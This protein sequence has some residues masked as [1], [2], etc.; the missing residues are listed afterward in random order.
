MPDICNKNTGVL[1][2][3]L[4]PK[5]Y[6][7]GIESGIKYEVRLPKAD[8]F[9]YTPTGERQSTYD[10]DTMSCATFSALN[11]IE[12]QVL[13]LIANGKINKEALGLLKE[14]GFFD[15]N[16]KFNCSDWFTANMSGTTSKGNDLASV[17]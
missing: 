9:N 11:S 17:W 10:F 6:V 13:W 7:A 15:A 4:S 1:I 8:W 3:P 16:G 5:A 2:V 14:Q 12:M